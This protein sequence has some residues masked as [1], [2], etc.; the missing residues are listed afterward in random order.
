MTNQPS[1]TGGTLA[2]T[3]VTSKIRRDKIGRGRPRM[4]DA[5]VINRKLLQAALQEFLAHGYGKASL[6]RVVKAAEASKSTLYSRY[7]SKEELFLAI[8]H[9]QIQ[10]LAPA[11]SLQTDAG[12]MGLEQGLTAYASHMLK[13][14]L[15]GELRGVDRLIYSESHQFPELAEAARARTELGVKRLQTFIDHCSERDGIA[16]QNPR[17]VA[18][19]FIFM[20]RGWYADIVLSNREVT[21]A[22]CERWV[23]SAVH[24]IVQGRAGW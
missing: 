13:R 22:E 14:S 21:A 18:E 10:Q 15:F 20:I 1:R 8:I 9:E 6:S 12:T 5:E 3:E 7:A 11:T 17:A 24:M 19:N 23:Q 4:G 2:A 16:C